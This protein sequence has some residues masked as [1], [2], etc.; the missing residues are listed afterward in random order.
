MYS[1]STADNW[2]HK[3]LFKASFLT[4]QW[5]SGDLNIEDVVCVNSLYKCVWRNASLLLAHDQLIETW[6]LIV[7][8]Q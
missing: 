8:V 5:N 1:T 7:S 3:L 4:Y 2:D 6:H